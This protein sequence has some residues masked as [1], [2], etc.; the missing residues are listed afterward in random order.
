MVGHLAPLL[1]GW[2]SDVVLLTGGK[3]IPPE[4]SHELSERK[5]PV[6]TQPIRALEGPGEKLE[7]IVFE[8]GS[9]LAREGLFVVAEQRPVPLVASL[10]L[11]LDSGL[12]FLKPEVF[13]EVDEF[14]KT[15]LPKLWAAG[16]CTTFRQAVFEAVA[17]GG[18]AAVAINAEL[19]LGSA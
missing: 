13:V 14:Q 2:S 15:S 5:V 19:T 8:D 3:D 6:Y 4:V 12:P 1:R 10:D 17:A 18:R 11:K 7:Q 16:D 9:K